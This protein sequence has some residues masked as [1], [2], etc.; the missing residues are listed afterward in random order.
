M[1]GSDI[2]IVS[3]G[4]SSIL[5]GAS[6][7]GYSHSG[8][9]GTITIFGQDEANTPITLGVSYTVCASNGSLES[10]RLANEYVGFP[11]LNLNSRQV[12]V[13][14]IGGVSTTP[15]QA[16][17]HLFDSYINFGISVRE[18]GVGF[19]FEPENEI[20]TN[21]I[22]KV[23]NGICLTPTKGWEI[24]NQPPIANLEGVCITSPGTTKAEFLIYNGTCQQWRNKPITGPV[25]INKDGVTTLG[26]I[27]PQSIE[28][29]TWSGK[30]TRADFSTLDGLHHYMF[31]TDTNLGVSR[32]K[33]A[34]AK[35]YSLDSTQPGISGSLVYISSQALV[36]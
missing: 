34:L 3:S 16:K 10:I 28:V 12:K 6:G 11:Y 7:S 14:P 13:Q 33:D 18:K 1:V 17:V 32:I 20:F 25:T 8:T 29:D 31:K 30:I 9:S 23:N 5:I 36:F 4:V 26:G 22:L 27:S 15:A 21:G 2:R 35:K 24:I 19:R